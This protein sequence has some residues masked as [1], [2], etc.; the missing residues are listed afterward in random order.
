MM[1]FDRENMEREFREMIVPL[2]EAVAP[3]GFEEEAAAVV[4]RFLPEVLE[5]STD[6]LNNLIAHRP[7]RGPKV[8][9]VAHLD[10]IGLIVRAIDSRGFLWFETLAG[11]QPQQLVIGQRI[12]IQHLVGRFLPADD[13]V[14]VPVAAQPGA[15]EQFQKPQLELV[16]REGINIVKRLTIAFIPFVLQPGDQV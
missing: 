13:A 14:F 1:I 11:V 7:G 3:T 2:C 8:A 10:E 9:V 16:G 15:F 4:R 5:L 12:G 6:R